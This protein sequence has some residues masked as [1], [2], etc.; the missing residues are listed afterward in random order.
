M[1]PG[2]SGQ[3]KRLDLLEGRESVSIRRVRKAKQMGLDAGEWVNMMMGA[4]GS[5]LLTVSLFPLG[6][7][8]R[9]SAE[10]KVWRIWRFEERGE[11]MK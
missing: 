1:A 11:G 5:S 6:E 7:K 9:S 2:S 3:V 4:C 10:N 8:A